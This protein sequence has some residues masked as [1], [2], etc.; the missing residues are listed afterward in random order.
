VSLVVCD[1][2][3]LNYLI[4]I[5]NIDVLP[6]LFDRLLV[7]PAVIREMQHRNAPPPVVAWTANLPPW[8][9][10]KAPRTDLHLNIG[11][12][13]DE[14]ISLAVE[15][16]NIALLVDDSR[17]RAAA[18]SRGLIIFGTLAILNQADA[19]GLL[20]F[21]AA[22]SR[23]RATNFRLDDTAVDPIVAQV[24]ARKQR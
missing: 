5:G 16:G 10:I 11:A 20:D 2:T 1:T 12:G 4:L 19:A 21:D 3:P 17:A 6:R 9:E 18:T 15:L 8:I 13:E 7:P 23:L 14:A 24:R 22:L